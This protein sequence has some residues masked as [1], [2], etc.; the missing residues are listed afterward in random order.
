MSLIKKN[1]DYFLGL[2]EIK[3]KLHNYENNNAKY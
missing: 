1:K 2:G 3:Y